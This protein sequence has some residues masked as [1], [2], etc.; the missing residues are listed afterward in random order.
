MTDKAK[1]EMTEGSQAQQ[2]TCTNPTA[3][4]DMRVYLQPA[5][6]I[7]VA[8]LAIAG[9]GISIAV[10]SFG[11]Y[12]KKEPLPLRKSLDLLDEKALA[13][14]KVISKEKIPYEETVKGLGTENYIQWTLEDANA[15]AD[16]R[17]RYCSLFITYYDLPDV[18]VH[19]PEE[20]YMGGGYQRLASESLTVDCQSVVDNR[21]FS[22]PASYLVF[23]DTRSNHWRGDTKFPVLY[24]FNVNG[25]YANSRENTRMILNK[26][27]FGKYSYF[28]KVEWNFFNTRL[29]A[30][31]QLGGVKSYPGREQAVA[32]SQ[33]LLSVILPIL[34]QEHWP[35][36]RELGT[37]GGQ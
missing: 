28:C 18:V 4:N 25:D 30:A 2:K 35:I 32:A 22:V 16:S 3:K 10:R 19:V 1:Y 21:Q 36:M 34:E 11:V 12:L 37:S 29:T 20:C 7:C 5:F 17:T 33:K 26:N 13:F 14:Y 8:I 15:A 6:L 23:S 27:I 9:S 24:L 31:G